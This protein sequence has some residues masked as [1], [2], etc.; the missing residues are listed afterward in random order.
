M[1]RTHHELGL[2]VPEQVPLAGERH[3]RDRLLEAEPPMLAVLGV[4]D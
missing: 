4:E 3:K 2:H 1:G